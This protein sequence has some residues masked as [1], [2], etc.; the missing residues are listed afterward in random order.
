MAYAIPPIRPAGTCGCAAGIRAFTLA[1]RQV[2][3]SRKFK[4]EMPPR[5]NDATNPAAFLQ[6]Y[7]EVF[8]EAGDDGQVMAN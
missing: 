1:L 8:L 4:P 5:Y 2:R 7:E 6:A 3:W